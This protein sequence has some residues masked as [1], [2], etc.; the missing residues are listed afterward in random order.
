MV[1]AL[2]GK[3]VSQETLRQEGAQRGHMSRMS[4]YAITQVTWEFAIFPA[5][6]RET[7][8]ELAAA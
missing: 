8:E 6:L 1:D 7:L 3:E 5:L 2:E 4:G